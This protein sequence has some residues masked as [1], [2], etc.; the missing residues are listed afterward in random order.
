MDDCVTLS[1]SYYML[2]GFLYFSQSYSPLGGT[3][4]DN[5]TRQAE[6]KGCSTIT[7]PHHFPLTGQSCF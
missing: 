6:L 3:C 7:E 4:G 1:N 2:C 5:P